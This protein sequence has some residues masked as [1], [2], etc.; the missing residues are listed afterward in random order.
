MNETTIAGK[1]LVRQL[2]R[3]TER[4]MSLEE[5]IEILRISSQ[6]RKLAEAIFRS[7]LLDA[8]NDIGA[9]LTSAQGTA[10]ERGDWLSWMRLSWARGV[11]FIHCSVAL[12]TTKLGAMPSK[13]LAVKIERAARIAETHGDHV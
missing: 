6:G 12:A 7:V 1:L 5:A 4:G 3:I 13:S 2:E 10:A 11:I 8:R 9:A